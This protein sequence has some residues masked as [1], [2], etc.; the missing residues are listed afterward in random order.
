[1]KVIRAEKF[2]NRQDVE[3]DKKSM[4]IFTDNTDRDSGKSLIPND[5]WYSTK[6]GEGKHYPKV[7][8]ALIRG[9]EN[10]YPITT[11][12]WYN[13]EHKGITG[14]WNDEDI[15]EFKKVIDDDFDEIY[16]HAKEFKQIIFPFQGIFNSKISNIS[17]SRTPILKKYLMEKCM[18]LLRI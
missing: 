14:R 13:P 18:T 17:D 6:Y 16:K 10:A 1:M 3:Q 7:T 11:Q 8:T 15:E 5:S 2:Y 9:L 4:Y 12:H